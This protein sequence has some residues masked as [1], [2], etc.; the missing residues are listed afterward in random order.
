MS[1][2]VPEI[3]KHSK[4]DS[5][6]QLPFSPSNAAK[7]NFEGVKLYRSKN[8]NKKTDIPNLP[9][10]EVLQIKKEADLQQKK[11]SQPTSSEISPS[12][13]KENSS[14]VLII[15]LNLCI[16]LYQIYS[17]NLITT[18]YSRLEASLAATSNLVRALNQFSF[19][20]ENRIIHLEEL[21]KEKIQ[22]TKT[23]INSKEVNIQQQKAKDSS[24][25]K[26]I[27]EKKQNGT[28]TPRQS[29]SGRT[30][31]SHISRIRKYT[32]PKAKA[33]ENAEAR[34]N[35]SLNIN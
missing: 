20:T 32:P 15:L 24:R 19:Q 22:P 9:Q 13:P 2:S 5:L 28:K 26:Q 17:L 7:Q 23:P 25:A 18:K 31:I 27:I 1:K 4:P 29:R 35:S 34:A 8:E 14:I 21:L 10:E 33:F 11:N 12:A 16:L 3:K 30:N 6:E